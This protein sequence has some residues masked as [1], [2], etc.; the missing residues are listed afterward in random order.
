MKMLPTAHSYENIFNTR[1]FWGAGQKLQKSLTSKCLWI[2]VYDR[3]I[4]S[5]KS[6]HQVERHEYSGIPISRTLGFPNLPISR[7]KPCCHWVCFTNAPYS[8]FTPHFSNP[9][10]LETPITRINFFFFF[11]ERFEYYMCINNVFRWQMLA[12]HSTRLKV[13]N[14]ILRF[15]TTYRR[16]FENLNVVPMAT[17]DRD[18][19]GLFCESTWL[20]DLFL[21]FYMVKFLCFRGNRVNIQAVPTN[22]ATRKSVH[23]FWWNSQVSFLTRITLMYL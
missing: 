20:L 6:K 3:T 14:N 5:R 15:Q 2:F 21:G 1:F 22:E 8:S 18:M 4:S 7:T 12:N 17:T 23:E 19:L 9:R 10:F 13:N 11:F 16:L